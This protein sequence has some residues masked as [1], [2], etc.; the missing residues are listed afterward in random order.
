MKTD[1]E[2]LA[3]MPSL[4]LAMVVTM[5]RS[6][7]TNDH[8]REEWRGDLSYFNSYQTWHTKGN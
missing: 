3:I 7:H 1:E 2:Y 4:G 8:M 5:H 6:K